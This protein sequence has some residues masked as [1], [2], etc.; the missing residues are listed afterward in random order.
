[1]IKYKNKEV[2]VVKWMLKDKGFVQIEY[3]GSGVDKGFRRTCSIDELTGTSKKDLKDLPEH[4]LE[5]KE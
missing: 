1:M 5:V 3:L 2:K 4:E